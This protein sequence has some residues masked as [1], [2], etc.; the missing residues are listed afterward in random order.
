VPNPIH[1]RPRAGPRIPAGWKG[2]YYAVPTSHVMRA[3][4]TDQFACRGAARAA[5]ACPAISVVGP[6]GGVTSVDREAFVNGY[7]GSSY[8][9]RWGELGWVAL[10]A[11]VMVVLALASLRLINHQ[12]R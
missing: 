6:S 11:G 2:L 7:L 4:G 9:D 3:L 5:G 8:G 10:A 1:P 12:K